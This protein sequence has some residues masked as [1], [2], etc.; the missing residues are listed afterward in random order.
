MNPA[1]KRL[2]LSPSDRAVILHAD[3]IGLCQASVEAFRQLATFG[4]V[5]SGAVMVP[6]PWFPAAAALSRQLDRPDLGVH[7]TLTCEWDVMRWGPLSTRDPQS[8]LMDRGGFF[9]RSNQ[10]VHSQINPAA[11]KKELRMQVDRALEAGMDVTHIDTH[12]G[13]VLHPAIFPAYM[14][15]GLE[16]RLPGVFPRWDVPRL[17]GR[18]LDEASA[19]A[20]ARA[21]RGLEEAGMP[22]IDDL[23][24]M[25]LD[26]PENRF[27][28][29]K[30]LLASL[31]PGLTHFVF[32]P[33][34][35]TPELRALAGDW[36]DRSADVIVFQHP[37]IKSFLAEEGITVL[38]YRQM[39]D[40]WRGA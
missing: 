17:R 29:A 26:K 10:E 28:Q 13:T 32:H 14:E 16:R 20:A 21:L 1:L 38:T 25:P 24:G 27:V 9:P 8:G 37:E 22:L 5:R 23:V 39:R 7:L 11:V 3:D 19:S 2:G 15:L 4:L 36:A 35:D 40:A 6:C 18:G 34:V 12:M 31:K 33:A 30:H